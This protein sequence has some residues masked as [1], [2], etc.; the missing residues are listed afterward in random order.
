MSARPLCFGT[1]LLAFLSLAGGCVGQ[2]TSSQAPPGDLADADPGAPS[3]SD[4]SIPEGGDSTKVAL[5]K[6]GITALP[7]ASEGAG[8]E[9]TFVDG[10]IVPTLG[11]APSL[12]N[13]VLSAVPGAPPKPLFVGANR[14]MDAVLVGVAGHAGYFE[15]AAGGN[16][17]IGLDVVTQANA[18]LGVVTLVIAVKNGTNVSETSTV[19]LFV[20]PHRFVAAGDLENHDSDGTNIADLF[21]AYLEG[22]AGNPA[23][24]V[25]VLD[26]TDNNQIIIGGVKGPSGTQLTGHREVVWDGV[27]EALRNKDNFNPEFFDRQDAGAAGVRGGIIFKSGGVG[28]EVNDAFAGAL[29]DAALV[30]PPANENA[31][32]GGDFSNLSSAFS[33]NLLAFTQSAAFAPLGSTSTEITFRVPGST[34]PATVHGLGIVFS[35]VDKAN[36]SYVEYFDEAGGVVAKIFSPV[37]DKGRFPFEGPAIAERFSYTFVGFNDASKRIARVV[38]VSGDVPIDEA[39]DD[40]PASPGDVV[41][42]DDVY[43]SEPAQ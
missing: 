29:P 26:G 12:S 8:L 27:P 36:S 24:P 2:V 37:Q 6:V 21:G 10:N 38:V 19:Q 20:D 40:F 9:G 23:T 4:A 13:S 28:Q 14:P 17:T 5:A 3:E 35:S 33:G 34:T 41:I 32:V 42:F 31:P 15:I 25:Q 11:T 18:P 30:G 43:Y 7:G 39:Q 1:S 22:K 16:S